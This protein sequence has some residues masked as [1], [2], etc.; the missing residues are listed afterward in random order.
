MRTLLLLAAVEAR[1]Y[2]GMNTI[3]NVG[4]LLYGKA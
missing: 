3:V 4:T 1:E 2:G